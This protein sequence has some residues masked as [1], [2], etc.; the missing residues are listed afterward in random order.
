MGALAP[1]GLAPYFENTPV[2][3]I[4]IGLHASL[5]S[6]FESQLTKEINKGSG[7]AEIVNEQRPLAGG[8][9][10]VGYETLG[11]GGCYFHSWLCHDIPDEAYRQFGISPNRFGLIDNLDDARRANDHLPEAGAEPAI[12]ET[13]APA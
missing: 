9:T 4:G 12:W 10:A 7:L 5:L 3:V 1:E 8:G 13:W 11:F 6:S 2:H